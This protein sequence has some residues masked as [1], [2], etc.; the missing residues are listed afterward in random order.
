MV[1]SC[2][3]PLKSTQNPIINI[4]VVQTKVNR[5]SISSSCSRVVVHI[6][7][8]FPQSYIIGTIVHN[9]GLEYALA[10][11]WLGRIVRRCEAGPAYN[12]PNPSAFTNIGHNAID[13]VSRQCVSV[14][15]RYR[16][17]APCSDFDVSFADEFVCCLIVPGIC[18]FRRWVQCGSLKWYGIS[19]FV[20]TDC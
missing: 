15:L 8:S 9:K 11:V 5:T 13:S 3:M 20:L 4:A 6:I 2:G 18:S 7:V 19:S 1:H 12:I 14:L 10:Q 17:S 16:L